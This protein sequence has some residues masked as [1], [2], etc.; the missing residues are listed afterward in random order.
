MQEFK[1]KGK[2]TQKMTRE[3]V[4]ETNQA[5]GEQTR[6]SRRETDSFSDE[7]AGDLTG[8][9][10]D[11]AALEK[12]RHKAKKHRRKAKK[13]TK[14]AKETA[15]QQQPQASRLQFTD[16]AGRY[17]SRR[18]QLMEKS[19]WAAGG[20]GR[21]R[22]QSPCPV[23]VQGQERNG[24]N[25]PQDRATRDRQKRETRQGG[26]RNNRPGVQGCFRL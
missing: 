8:K 9:A 12:Q 10:L 11:R 17:L 18:L 2:V 7:A 26:N 6:T 4:V 14:R 5:T 24:E 19:V 23:P 16:E 22:Y 20:K 25:R 15:R 3:G 13:E 21:K 1:A